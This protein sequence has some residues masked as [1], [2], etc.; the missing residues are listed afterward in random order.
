MSPR[1]TTTVQPKWTREK[2]HALID[3]LEENQHLWWNLHPDYKSA[4]IRSAS[5]TTIA[6]RLG[7]VKDEILT[8]IHNLRCQLRNEKKREE[9]RTQYKSKWEYY[10]KLQF[11]YRNFDGKVV[12]K[13]MTAVCIILPIY[14]RVCECMHERR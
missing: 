4:S 6:T 2:I 9:A 10:D 1:V 7:F 8:K 12:T 11:L 3:Y 13:K 5:I 14:L